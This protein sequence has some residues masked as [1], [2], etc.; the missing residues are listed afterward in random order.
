MLTIVCY[1]VLCL[2]GLW[3]FLKYSLYPQ[4]LKKKRYVKPENKYEKQKMNVQL[5]VH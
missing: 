3:Q 5:I 2:D 1:L 4:K